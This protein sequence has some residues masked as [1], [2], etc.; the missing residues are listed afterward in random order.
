MRPGSPDDLL[1]YEGPHPSRRR[2]IIA[3][4]IMLKIE[5]HHLLK[6]IKTTARIR[7]NSEQ[8]AGRDPSIYG[9]TGY[10]LSSVEKLLSH[11]KTEVMNG[12]DKRNNLANFTAIVDFL[13]I[14]T[15]TSLYTLI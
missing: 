11:K 15:L 13:L 8:I 3:Q 6:R 9:W 7:Y 4:H 5:S 14:F 12:T 1:G 10:C 2:K